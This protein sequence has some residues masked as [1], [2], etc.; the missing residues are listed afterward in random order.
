MLIL[1]LKFILT[2]YQQFPWTHINQPKISW[3]KIC[4]FFIWQKSAGFIYI[5]LSTGFRSDCVWHNRPNQPFVCQLIILYLTKISQY[6]LTDGWKP[7]PRYS[8]SRL[9][10]WCQ[11]VSMW[12]KE[13]GKRPRLS[14]SASSTPSIQFS[15]SVS[16]AIMMMISPSSKVNSSSLSASQSYSARHF[17]NRCKSNRWKRKRDIKW[18]TSY[19]Y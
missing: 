3:T 12:T 18:C 4:Q 10:S 2:I 17:L 1:F 15:S 14:G 16:S 11:S 7:P 13:A 8:P 9:S 6:Q 5:F 19:V